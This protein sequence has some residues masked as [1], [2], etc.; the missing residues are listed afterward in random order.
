MKRRFRTG[1]LA[2][3]SIKRPVAVTMLALSVVVLGVFSLDRLRIDLLPHI[4]YPEVRV[5]ILD[6]GVPANIMEDKITRQLEEQLSITEGAI[7]VQSSTSEGASRVDLSFPYGTDIDIALRDASTRLD[8]AKRFLPD[9]I[10]PPIIYKRDPSQIPVLELAVSSTSMGPV[11]LREWVDYDFSRWFVNLPGVAAAEVG[12]GNLREIQIIVDQERLASLGLTFSDL[13]E[14]I[15]NNNLEAPGGRLLTHTREI[16][17]R[18]FGRFK[19]IEEIRQLPLRQTTETDKK[20]VRL[21][22]VAR[23]VDLYEDERLRVRLNKKSAIKLSIQKQPQANT[24]SVVDV[25]LE[26]LAW[27][28]EQSLIPADITVSRVSDQ[29][30]FVRHALRNA[31]MA[32]ISGAILAMIVVYLFLGSIRRTLIIGT[33]IPLAIMVTF[34]IMSLGGL[35]L[36]IMTLGGIALGVGLLIDSTIIMLE[37]ITRHQ[38][39]GEKPFDAALNAATEINSAIVASTSTNLAAILPFLFITGLVGLLFSELIFTL[40]AAISASLLVALTL[41]PSLGA[42]IYDNPA[43]SNNQNRFQKLVDRVIDSLKTLLNTV[44][45]RIL[46]TPWKPFIILLPLLFVALIYLFY[47]SK[48]T[49][50]P[51]VDEGQIRVYVKADSGTQFNDLDDISNRLE[52]LFLKQKEVDTVFTTSGGFIFGRTERLSSNSGSI[53]I[54]L[55]SGHE[56]EAWIKSMRKEISKLDLAGV[57]VRLRA[58]GVRGIRLSQGDDDISIRVQGPD[59]DTLSSIG[60]EV[61]ERIDGIKGLRN[62]SQ[63]YEEVREV[64]TVQIDKERAAD[65]NIQVS[66]IGEALRVALEGQIISEYLEGDRSHNIRL[67]L[68]VNEMLTPSDLENV[69][70]GI[71]QDRPVRL[72]QVAQVMLT[73]SPS[74]I[75]RDNQRRI[76]EIGASLTANADLGSIMNQIESRLTDLEL[77]EGYSI[78]DGGATKTLKEGK[79]L[80]LVLFGLAIFLVFVVMAIQYESLLNPVI[81]LLSIP[82]AIIGVALGILVTQ[83]VVSMPVWLGMIMLAGIV[84][85]N[86]IV[87]VE[88][89]EIERESG[90]HLDQAIVRAASLRLRPILMTTLTTVFGMLPL[91][92]GLGRG[93]EMLQPLAIVLVWG[94]FFSMLVSLVIVPAIYKLIRS[95]EHHIPLE[96]AI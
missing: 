19:N 1:G 34:I 62:L 69:L 16:S 74:T 20:I 25:V 53:Y 40:T 12:G 54:Q 71:Y 95:K 73:Q 8:R 83:T 11:K 68:P 90:L 17:T 48:Q 14:R 77:P 37:N 26:R 41:V 21:R 64:V 70:V 24:V 63:T 82:F 28:K 61:V 7:S 3:W 33:A 57:K 49:F 75:M 84:V 78:Y 96:T 4:I 52:T 27:L 86:A 35:T 66:D 87:L 85:N 38:R 50:L 29:S 44:L 79:K 89:I 67:R 30:T 92:L 22:D 51:T 93:S 36:N 60:A 18:A 47:F 23:V 72:V 65:L 45:T 58:R 42:R 32:A 2:A 55:H 91:A 31:S 81:I 13:K 6:P 15:Q 46:V 39:E 94:L 10:D 5:R 76:V 80:G 9:T 56:T 43:I 88:Q 59:L